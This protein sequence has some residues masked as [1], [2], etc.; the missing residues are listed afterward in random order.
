MEV[1]PLAG[2][3][4]LV[5]RRHR[6]PLKHQHMLWFSGLRGAI[7]FSLALHVPTPHGDVVLTST[8]VIVLVSV[9]VLGGGTTTLLRLLRIRTGIDPG[10]SAMCVRAL[11]KVLLLRVCTC[12]SNLPS[13]YI[14][15][16]SHE[17]L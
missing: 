8:L 2:I 11:Y 5:R 1:Y 7:A 13:A 12:D 10:V 14:F 6:I 9:L 4:N 15:V 3:I 17:N 16:F